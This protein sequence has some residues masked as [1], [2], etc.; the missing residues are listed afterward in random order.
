MFRVWIWFK[1]WEYHLS[2]KAGPSQYYPFRRSKYSTAQT[3]LRQFGLHIS[4]ARSFTSPF[5]SSGDDHW[6]VRAPLPLP[7]DTPTAV[8]IDLILSFALDIPKSHKQIDPSSRTKTLSAFK[9]P[10]MIHTSVAC[11]YATPVAVSEAKRLHGDLWKKE[12]AAVAKDL[13]KLSAK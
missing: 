3:T 1:V 4:E 9:S 13:T 8:V 11:K 12:K 10:W 2:T 6:T 7:E 5:K